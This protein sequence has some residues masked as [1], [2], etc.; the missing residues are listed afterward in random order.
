MA[1]PT[2][3]GSEPDE[4]N[5]ADE[6]PEEEDIE[7]EEVEVEEDEDE[8]EEL[9]PAKER[10]RLKSIFRR[11][12]TDP[13]YIRVHDVVIKG[14]SKTKDAVI[15]AEISDLF[16][17]PSTMQELVAAASIAN[18]RLKQLDVF[19]SVSITLDAGPAELPGTTNVVIEVAEAGNPLT[20]NVGVFSKPEV[21]IFIS[22]VGFLLNNY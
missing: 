14:N 18:A 1:T 17:K 10:E 13:V 16:K 15:E 12:N 3:S 11:L 4:I 5:G 9:D 6:V 7:F 21:K 2:V 20:G 22:T 8:D 19:D